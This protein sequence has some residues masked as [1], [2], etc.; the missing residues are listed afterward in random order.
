MVWYIV[1]L[2]GAV[3]YNMVQQL[4]L[5]EKLYKQKIMLKSIK[6]EI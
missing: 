2:Y 5:N 1:V 3:W 6:I 4:K